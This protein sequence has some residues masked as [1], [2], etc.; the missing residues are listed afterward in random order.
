ML[1]ASIAPAQAFDFFGLFGSSEKPPEVAPDALSYSLQ[2]EISGQDP[3]D[4]TD[5]KQALRDASTL[6]KLR[7]DR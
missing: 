3:A 1:T 6:Y 4:K 2:F 5:L 7:Q